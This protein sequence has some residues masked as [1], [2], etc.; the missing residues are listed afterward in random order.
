MLS[1]YVDADI[2]VQ[3]G[4]T[5]PTGPIHLTTENA[6]LDTDWTTAA[7]TGSYP[8]KLLVSSR[9]I[10]YNVHVQQI[11]SCFLL[12][13][14]GFA[15]AALLSYR[16]LEIS[17]NRSFEELTGHEK[18]GLDPTFQVSSRVVSIVV[19]NPSTK[20]L[21]RPVNITLRHLQV[22]SLVPQS[23]RCG[24]TATTALPLLIIIV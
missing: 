13:F 7:G 4:K 9:P 17:F 11:L 23:F 19:S 14:T 2:A 18:D 12:P 24:P 10:S 20:K 8:G 21:S 3:R 22:V 1:D 16:N 15:L 5:R 6:T